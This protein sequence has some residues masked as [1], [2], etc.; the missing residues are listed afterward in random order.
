M[1]N[2][3]LAQQAQREGM[4]KLM[5]TDEFVLALVTIYFAARKH[6]EVSSDD[7]WAWLETHSITTFLRP[8]A[9]GAAFKVAVQKGLIQA[10]G[11][12]I[13]S[14]RVSSHGRLV[15]IWKSLVFQG[16]AQ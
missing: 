15:Q 9:M 3:A 8:N 13:P 12:V 14:T 16:G 1:L 2:A 11:R 6:E 10:T 7:V 5:V 4:A